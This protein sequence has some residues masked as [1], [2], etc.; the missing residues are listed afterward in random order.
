MSNIYDFGGTYDYLDAI[1][2]PDSGGGRSPPWISE[3]YF[4]Y[5]LKQQ[6]TQFSFVIPGGRGFS[7]KGWNNAPYFSIDIL[8]EID[9]QVPRP[10]PPVGSDSLEAAADRYVETW[11]A[12]DRRDPEFFGRMAFTNQQFWASMKR[13]FPKW[14]TSL[15]GLAKSRPNDPNPPIGPYIAEA[16][17]DYFQRWN[18]DSAAYNAQSYA[19]PPLQGSAEWDPLRTHSFHPPFPP[20]NLQTFRR[21]AAA[22]ARGEY[23]F[24]SI[25]PSAWTRIM[26]FF[27]QAY[28]FSYG[29]GRLDPFEWDLNRWPP[30]RTSI[31]QRE[32]GSGQQPSAISGRWGGKSPFMEYV[33]HQID[34]VA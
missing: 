1:H 10:I 33:D 31:P 12:G 9:T 4:F 16:M 22:L 6:P 17:E 18:S 8:L 5:L 24:A 19:L 34:F 26:I 29:Y 32:G 23:S 13:K 11:D 30:R 25:P 20:Q 3:P 14:A 28:A 15:N 7:N 2:F 21:L 27:T